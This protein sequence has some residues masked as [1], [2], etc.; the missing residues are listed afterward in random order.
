M[1]NPTEEE[2]RLGERFIQPSPRESQ[3]PE[4][5]PTQ[6]LEQRPPMEPVILNDPEFSVIPAEWPLSE[7][8][9]EH[10]LPQ[11]R[12]KMPEQAVEPRR[13][14]RRRAEPCWLK[15]GQ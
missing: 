13:S 9:A 7:P 10:G 11:P 1:R 6:Q 2:C 5:E 14:T 3:Q 15:E 12:A 4:Q 8:I